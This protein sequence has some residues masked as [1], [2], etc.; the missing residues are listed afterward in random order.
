MVTPASSVTHIHCLENQLVRI[1]YL[2]QERR[3]PIYTLKEMR[4]TPLKRDC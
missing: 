3:E 1:D 4:N 2:M